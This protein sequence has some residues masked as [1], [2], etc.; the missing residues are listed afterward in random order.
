MYS[1][2]L[3]LAFTLEE[4]RAQIAEHKAEPEA[5]IEFN[6]FRTFIEHLLR[7]CGIQ[8][9]TGLHFR[10]CAAQKGERHVWKI[11][12][13]EADRDRWD[14]RDIIRVLQSTE[15]RNA[16]FGWKEWE[17]HLE[18]VALEKSHIGFW[19]HSLKGGE[20]CCS[21]WWNVLTW[22]ASPLRGT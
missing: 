16:I 13:I 15:E 11:T 17:R 8:R 5:L 19:R 7:M 14:N 21:L 20:E 10:N 6:P 4:A 18:E 9:W 12:T 22:F 2:E 1:I 3:L